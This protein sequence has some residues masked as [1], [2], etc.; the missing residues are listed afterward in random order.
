ME[1][2]DDLDE[3]GFFE[4]NYGSDEMDPICGRKFAANFTGIWNYVH[5]VRLY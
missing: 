3:I 4:S 1:E 2:R 5:L